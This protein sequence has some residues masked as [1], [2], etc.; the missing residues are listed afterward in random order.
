MLVEYIRVIVS[1]LTERG[2]AMERG[3]AWEIKQMHQLISR[4]LDQR[5]Y[6]VVEDKSLT[7]MQSMVL[8]YI[9]IK[10]KKGDV[11]QKDIEQE[12][13]IRRSTATVLLQAL[14]KKGLIYREE[15][16]FDKRIKHI[17][18]TKTADVIQEKVEKTFTEFEQ[19][20]SENLTEEEKITFFTVS[21]KMKERLQERVINVDERIGKTYQTI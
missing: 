10:S 6:M 9:Y 20:L 5:I 11:L 21:N 14:E 17:R 2:V 12:F 1:K 13:C 7:R 16:D 3:I 4:E 15:C 8:G 18:L 19:W